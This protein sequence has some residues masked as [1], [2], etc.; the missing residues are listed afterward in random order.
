MADDFVKQVLTFYEV[1]H[2]HT[3]AVVSE[4]VLFVCTYCCVL[5]DNRSQDGGSP[6]PL[7][8]AGES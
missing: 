5:S 7:F 3:H 1:I 4:F 8:V 2:L 6:V